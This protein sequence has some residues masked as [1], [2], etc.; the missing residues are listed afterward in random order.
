M[1]EKRYEIAVEIIKVALKYDK[2]LSIAI[3]NHGDWIADEACNNLIED[4]DPD[5]V[6]E[7]YENLKKHLRLA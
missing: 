6:W 3:E 1:K 5:E 4:A 7:I 2:D